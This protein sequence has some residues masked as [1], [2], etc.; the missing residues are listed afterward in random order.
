LGAKEHKRQS[1]KHILS[2]DYNGDPA[3]LHLSPANPDGG[4]M[5]GELWML[6]EIKDYLRSIR[7]WLIATVI[8]L[9][10]LLI[11]IAKRGM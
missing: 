2:S 10:V 6:I 9:L 1:G 3:V 4:K 8:L 7:R 11:L 5:S